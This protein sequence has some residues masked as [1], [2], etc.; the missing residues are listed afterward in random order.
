MCF[1]VGYFINFSIFWYEQA[2]T[3]ELKA[4]REM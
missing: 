4:N 3:Y 2:G 1:S